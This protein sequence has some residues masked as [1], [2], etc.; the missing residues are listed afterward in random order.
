MKL[1]IINKVSLGLF[2][3]ALFFVT[4][5]VK[6][7]LILPDRAKEADTQE[8]IDVITKP[9]DVLI[10]GDYNFAFILE[11]AKYISDN[12]QALHLSY[13]KAGV[14]DAEKIDTLIEDF[15]K[16]FIINTEEVDEYVFETYYLSKSGK[17]SKTVTQKVKNKDLHIK[18]V[19]ASLQIHQ[20]YFSEFRLE[21]KGVAKEKFKITYTV[22]TEGDPLSQTL[23][24]DSSGNDVFTA[25]EGTYDVGVQVSDTLGNTV[26][27]LLSY[28]L[29]EVA[30]LTASDKSRWTATASDSHGG[31]GPEKLINGITDDDDHWHSNWN[32][33]A[34]PPKT[35]HPFTLEIDF[36]TEILLT[37]VIL[38]NRTGGNWDGTR[39]FDLYGFNEETEEYVL[40]GK[41]LE[42]EQLPGRKKNF[43]IDSDLPFSKIQLIITESWPKGYE[44]EPAGSA[45]LGEIDVKGFKKN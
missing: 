21:W 29:S 19:L 5:C 7:S 26:D 3:A 42:M 2:V 36:D 41:D 28:T 16:P 9:S 6:E 34:N 22:P 4:A 10:K 17:E 27:T 40:L 32:P 14:E 45:H 44:T 33:E 12:V 8:E 31:Q 15:S 11:W 39:F 35:K 37:E 23:V 30:Y 13:Y 38:H 18:T 24:T 25:I 20:E 43:T 1:T